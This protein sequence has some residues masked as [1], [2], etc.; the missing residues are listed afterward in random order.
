MKRDKSIL[1]LEDEHE[2]GEYLHNLL[3]PSYREV[4]YC[5]SA[6]K[7]KNIILER[8]FS[9]VLTDIMMPGLQGHEF[10]K[11]YRSAGRI[12]PVIFITGNTNREI[13]MTAVRLGVSDVLE[14]PFEEV[15]L[16][17]TIERTLEIEK[18]KES[19]YQLSTKLEALNKKKMIGLLQVANTK[20]A[21]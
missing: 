11:Y 19:V 2:I 6:L 21:I 16:L 9:L 1:I 3:I 14:K 8:T 20:K 4:V 15:D 10:L 5:D 12:E 7:A 13:L 17:K 18:R